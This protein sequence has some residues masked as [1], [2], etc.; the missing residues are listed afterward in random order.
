MDN[1][2]RT[3]LIDTLKEMGA[4]ITLTPGPDMAGEK[5]M[6]IRVRHSRLVG[7]TVPAEDGGAGMDSVSYAIVI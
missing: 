7:I 5:T 6:S 3:G 4:G 1:P 2:A